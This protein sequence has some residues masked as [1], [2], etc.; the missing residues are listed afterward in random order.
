MVSLHDHWWR[1][2]LALF[3]ILVSSAAT[4]RHRASVVTFVASYIE[5]GDCGLAS[6]LD[7]LRAVFA[8]LL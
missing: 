7:L 2:V 8:T 6:A 3:I 1:Q 4:L 5:A